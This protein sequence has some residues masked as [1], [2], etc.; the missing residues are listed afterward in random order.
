MLSVS[1]YSPVDCYKVCLILFSHFPADVK[2]SFFHTSYLSNIGTMFSY[3]PHFP[4]VLNHLQL[5]SPFP[6]FSF[7]NIV[8]NILPPQIYGVSSSLESFYNHFP[9]RTLIHIC[10][11]FVSYTFIHVT[12]FTPLCSNRQYIY[13]V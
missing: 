9:F 5:K 13:R 8:F 6:T 1:C 3:R 7:L 4:L 10:Y 12:H 2:Q 11:F